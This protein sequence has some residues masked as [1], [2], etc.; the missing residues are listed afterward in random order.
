MERSGGLASIV[1]IA[2]TAGDVIDGLTSIS[3]TTVGDSVWL[4]AGSSGWHRL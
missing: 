4:V 3:L 2:A 1:T